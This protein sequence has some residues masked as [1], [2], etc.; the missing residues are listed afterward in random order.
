MSAWPEEVSWSGALVEGQ[1]QQQAYQKQKYRGGK[2]FADARF[3]G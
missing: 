2:D 1:D 3:I